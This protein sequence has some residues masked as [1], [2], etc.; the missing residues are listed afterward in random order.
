MSRR[1]AV[2]ESQWTPERRARVALARR[3]DALG[4]DFHWTWDFDGTFGTEGT[5]RA[6]KFHRFEDRDPEECLRKALAVLDPE[7][8]DA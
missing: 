6:G 8:V 2:D 7:G 3:V 5:D 4:G 1:R